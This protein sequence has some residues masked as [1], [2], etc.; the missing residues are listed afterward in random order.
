M[1][2]LCRKCREALNVFYC[3]YH[4]CSDFENLF[5]FNI[6]NE[7]ANILIDYV[8]LFYRIYLYDIA[9]ATTSTK[10]NYLLSNIITKF[11][12]KAHLIYKKQLWLEL[13]ERS[14]RYLTGLTFTLLLLHFSFEIVFH[15]V[16]WISRKI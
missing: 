16:D 1:M 11:N 7:F 9:T 3:Q 14:T 12:E 15:V 4:V 8:K 13:F 10:H 2:L 6:N 5:H